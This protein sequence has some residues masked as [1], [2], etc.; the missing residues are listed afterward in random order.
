MQELLHVLFGAERGGCEVEAYL[1][2]RTLTNVRHRVL[3]LGSPGPLCDA[4]R[5]AGAEV[6]THA[7]ASPALHTLVN[8]V[9]RYA[10]ASPPSAVMIWHG[11]VQLP[12]IL[13]GLRAHRMPIGIYGGNPTHGMPRR[14]ELKYQLLGL[15]YRPRK[16][17]P[18]FIC[19]SEH[20]ASSF[21]S[22]PYLRQFQRIVIYNGVEVPSTAAGVPRKIS[23]SCSPVIGMVARLDSI[24]DHR[25]LVSA[26]EIVQRTYPYATL[27]LAGDGKESTNLREYVDCL[28]LS[29]K[30]R[31]LGEVSDVYGAMAHWDL[32]AY[33]TTEREGLGNVVAEAMMFG[34]PCVVTDVGPMREFAGAGDAV[35]LVRAADSGALAKA[36]CELIPDAAARRGLSTA[37]QA[38][39]LSRFH[40]AVFARHYAKVLGLPPPNNGNENQATA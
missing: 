29:A 4:W 18:T 28:G 14:V 8:I 26:F 40:P 7:P 33:A 12:Q 9:R 1:L 19:C 5:R 10:A 11:L 2:I 17:L 35:R 31:F 22:S 6:A 39:A 15:L 36:I 32:F 25:T 24:K 30:V 13:Y 38:H 27:E 16:P 20:V 37:G 34:L 3:V 23:R 21:E